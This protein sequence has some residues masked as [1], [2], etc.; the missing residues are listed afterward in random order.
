MSNKQVFGHK[1][2]I[3][4]FYTNKTSKLF[5]DVH[6]IEFNDTNMIIHEYSGDSIHIKLNKIS[7]FT[8]SDRW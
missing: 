1:T 2:I 6:S 3:E 4:I 8:V 7:R 5:K